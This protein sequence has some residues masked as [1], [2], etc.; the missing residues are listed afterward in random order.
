MFVEATVLHADLDA[1]FAAVEQR[2]DP[3]LR[4]RPVIVGGGVVLAA[5]YEAKAFG[6]R[7]AMGLRRARSLC[8]QAIVVAPRMSAYSEASKDVYRVFDDTT[9]LVEGM[10]IDEAFLDVRGMQRVYGTPTEIA[11]RLRR[12]VRSRVGLPITVGIARTKFLAKVASGVAKPDGLLLVPP[13]DEIAFLHPLPVER[14]WGVGPVTARRL[15]DLGITTVG[16]VARFGE[17]ALVALLGPR[18]RPAP[19]RART[20]PRSPAGAG[21]APSPVDRRPAGPRT[22]ADVARRPRRVARRARRPRHAPD[23]DGQAGRP[24]GRPAPPLRRL[25]ARDPLA[26]AAVRDREHRGDPRSGQS[27]ARRGRAA[28]R[29]PRDHARRR[30]RQQPRRRQDDPARR[31]R[32]TAPAPMRSTPPST[33]CASGSG[34]ARSSAPFSSAGARASRCRSCRTELEIRTYVRFHVRGAARTRRAGPAGGHARGARIALGVRGGP[35]ALRH[36]LDLGRPR[37]LAPGRPHRRRQPD[38]LHRRHRSRSR[39]REPTRCWTRPSSS[40][41]T[42]RRPGSRPRATASA[43]SA[44]CACA[45]SSSSTPSS[46]SST[47]ESRSRLRSPVS[48]AC[49]SRS[50]GRRR[51]SQACVDRFLDF[52]GDA[53]LVA[54]NARFDQRFLEQQLLR[55]ARPAPV[56]AAALH[57]R[58]RAPPA[59]GTAPSRQPRL[60]GPLL[61]RRDQTLPPR[62]SRRRGDGAGAPAPDRPRAGARR[63]PPLGPARARRA[64]Q[65]PRL[66]QACA[67]EG[68]TDPA[69]RLPLSRPPRSG[70]LRRPRP[71]PPRASSLLLPQRAPAA[72]GRGGPARARPHRVARARL[73]A[74]GGARGAAADPRAAAAGELAQPP[75]GARRLPEAPRARSSSSRRRPP[76]SARSRAGGAPPWPRAPSRSARQR[77]STGSSRAARS[78]A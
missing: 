70:A 29:A 59:R 28:D 57:G 25:L 31:C 56:G 26:H 41:S 61:R 53:L 71:R 8:P 76:G 65:A 10:S 12:E 21:A 4:G 44:P 33:R 50:C 7:T 3:S 60:A 15:H 1:F 74:R 2:D 66:R 77:S 24:D 37:V 46:P 43:R 6:V 23:A 40:S 67:R 45:R 49:A 58:A 48:P 27:P 17:T 75:Q 69:R 18:L 63:A 22:Q 68:R 72:L 36:V 62:A 9:P 19:P 5:S 38:R 35:L 39:E 16:E 42:S 51:P 73:R 64:A 34:R 78:R 52:A 47:R 11:A 54:H 55:H 32:S 14:L 13:R 20:Q 30:L